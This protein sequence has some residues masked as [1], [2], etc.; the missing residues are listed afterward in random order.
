MKRQ[1]LV[2]ILGLAASA[3][4]VCG[5][6]NIYFDTYLASRGSPAG[7]VCWWLDST[8]VKDTDGFKADLLWSV[9]ALSGDL[10]LAVPT[11]TTLDGSGWINPPLSVSFD[12]MYVSGPI[13]LTIL[14]WQGASWS[15]SDVKGSLS[16]TEP[17]VI[18]GNPPETFQNMPQ[19]PIYV[20]IPIPEPTTLSLAGLGAAALLIARRR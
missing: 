14:V 19:V 11:S 15:T 1:L 12:P 9:G 5:Q 20:G 13:N 8:P 18:P 10:G 2:S 6:I 17:G 3:T 4:T 7:Q 16:W